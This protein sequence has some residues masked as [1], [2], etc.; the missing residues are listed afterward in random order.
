MK[1]FLLT[2]IL[3]FASVFNC[4]AQVMPVKYQGEIGFGY[5]IGVGTCATGRANVHTVQGAKIGDYFSAGVGTGLDYYHELSDLIIPVYLNMRGYYPLAKNF[6]PFVSLD[7]GYGIGVTKAIRGHSG[8]VWSP[9]VGFRCNK[10]KLQV[11]YTSQR[12]SEY[13]FGFNMNAIQ[14]MAGLVF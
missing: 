5:S 4:M 8:F 14:I 6:I 1:K 13:G 2:L 7:L 3:A 10:F 12:L 11:G 9:S